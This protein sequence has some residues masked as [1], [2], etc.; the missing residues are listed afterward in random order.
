MPTINDLIRANKK[1]P[2]GAKA[3]TKALSKPPRFSQG[4]VKSKIRSKHG[5][6]PGFSG[7]VRHKGSVMLL[8][9]DARGRETILSYIPSNT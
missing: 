4:N 3:K 2:R 8:R 6:P 5:F 7:M 1:P 9:V